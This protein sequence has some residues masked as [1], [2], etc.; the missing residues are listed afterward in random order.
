MKKFEKLDADT[1]ERA[2]KAAEEITRRSKETYKKIKGY[3]DQAHE[4]Y[5]R[6]G[7]LTMDDMRK[8]NRLKN[9][10]NAIAEA[11]E[12]NRI[13]TDK[14]I[15]K[16][17][18]DS[19]KNALY[20]C[21]KSGGGGRKEKSIRAIKKEIDVAEILDETVAG[22]NWK[23]RTKHLSA[24]T[25]YDIITEVRKGI[26]QGDSFH[27]MAKAIKKKMGEYNGRPITIAKTETHRVIE[28]TKFK[29]MESVSKQV[30]QLK[31][32]RTVSDERVRDSHKAMEGQTVKLDEEFTLPSGAK[33]MYPGQSGI[34][35]EDINCRCFVEYIDAPKEVEDEDIEVTENGINDSDK[36]YNIDEK[37]NKEEKYVLEKLNSAVG[38]ENIKEFRK[39]LDNCPNQD[40]QRFYRDYA[41]NINS[42][43]ITNDG[44]V[45]Q[46]ASNSIEASYPL[47]Y[48]EEGQKH[49]YSII[50]HEYG[51]FFDAKVRN[52]LN[53]T[54]IDAIKEAMDVTFFSKKVSSCSDEFLKAV[55]EDKKVLKSIG[56]KK[57]YD[58]L[59]NIDASSG[60]QDAVDGMFIGSKYRIGWGHG[61]KYYNRKF[62]AIKTIEKLSDEDYQTAIQQKLTE[63]GLKGVTKTKVKEFIRDHET[64]SEMWANILS[65]ITTNGDEIKYVKKYLPNSYKAAVSIMKGMGY[66]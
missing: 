41:D 21:T 27:D 1:A 45:Y 50:C 40:I 14:E 20:V 2:K 23:E 55:R 49:K 52:N 7:T 51:H 35:A 57:L 36:G 64:A 42:I 62:N 4:R 46:H 37:E 59:H 25:A 5:A 53:Y 63:L 9:L 26:D 8:F 65:A 24:N 60:V 11:M 13:L 16:L 47:Q 61:E 43:Q 3:L 66:E 12:E 39:L 29:A 6:K 15:A 48:G 28:T 32:W 33:T 31:V 17:L 58:D 30:P 34:A 38:D 54:E 56:Y 22:R 44:G 18:S 10:E 19:A